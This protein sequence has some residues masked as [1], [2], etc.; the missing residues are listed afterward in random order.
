MARSSSG[1][2]AGLTAAAL[3]A[4]GFLAYQASAN[5]PDQPGKPRPPSAAP[6]AQASGGPSRSRR[7]RWRCPAESGTGVR[8]VY[9]LATTGSGW[10]ARTARPSRTFEV[11]PG[12]VEPAARHVHGH[13][14]LR[15]RHRLGRRPD[16]ARGAV[17][18]RRRRVDR[19]QRGAWTARWPSPDPDRKT[20]GIRRRGRTATRC[21]S[22]RRSARRS[23]SSVAP[24]SSRRRATPAS[25]DRAPARVARPDGATRRRAAVHAPRRAVRARGGVETALA[26]AHDASR[27]RIDTAD[28]DASPAGGCCRGCDSRSDADMDASWGSGGR[29]S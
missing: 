28:G 25:R 29:R 26:A 4:V 1:L 27:S 16:R 6:S 18:Q 22:S 15:R 5:A 11:M 7:T 10:S 17:R 24:R 8:V 13:L 20:G 3:A 9:S 14:A 2:V 12:T 21:G 23:S 19:L